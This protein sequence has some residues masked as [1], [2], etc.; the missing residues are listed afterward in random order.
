MLSQLRWFSQ[1]TYDFFDLDL[2]HLANT[3]HPT[4]ALVIHRLC[5]GPSLSFSPLSIVLYLACSCV[6]LR[7]GDWPKKTA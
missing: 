2:Q 7:R 4:Y 3:A 5:L 1:G 6:A